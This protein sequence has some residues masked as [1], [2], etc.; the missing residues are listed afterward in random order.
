MTDKPLIVDN[1]DVSK[2]EF[3]IITN[4][5]HLCRCIKSDLF[6][7][8]EFVEN[9]RKGNCED[10]PN[11]YYKQLQREK[12]S[13]QESRDTSIKEFNRAEELNTLLKHKQQECDRLK[14][15][16][17]YQVGALEKTIDNLTA[18]NEDLE[19][20]YKELQDDMLACNKCRATIKLQQQLDQLKEDNEELKKQLQA[21]C[22]F[23][24]HEQKLIYC[25]AYDETC[26]TGNDC[27]QQ[28]CI[29]K[30]NIKLK[31]TLAEIKEIAKNMNNECFYDDFECKDCD[32][33][34]GCTYFNKKQILQK[35]SAI[36]IL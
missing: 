18:E 13:S 19:R 14:H 15:D 22:A 6:G 8:I 16:N 2:C 23:T 11:C 20:L 28:K 25:V 12:Q 1:I 21:Q 27:K 26:K 10:N 35:I 7:G 4:D 17:D 34:N 5:K 29:F 33:K 3:L 32:M 24:R 30:D 31:Q 36:R 9:A